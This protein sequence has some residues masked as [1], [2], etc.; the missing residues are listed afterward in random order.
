MG[1]HSLRSLDV[2]FTGVT[3]QGLMHLEGL[4]RLTTLSLFQAAVTKEGAEELQ[5]ANP[6]L[7]IRR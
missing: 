4:E 7:K 1:L 5:R 2:T 3:D 6:R